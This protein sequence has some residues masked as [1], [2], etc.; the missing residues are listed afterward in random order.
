MNRL[1]LAS[2]FA[3]SVAAVSQQTASAQ[4]ANNYGYL[5]FGFYQPYGATYGT[6]LRTPP[7][8]AMNPPVYYGA[9]HSRPYGISPFA[10]PPVVSAGANYHSRLRTQFEQ[11]RIPSPGPMMMEP[12]PTSNPLCNPCLSQSKAFGKE[13]KIVATEMGATKMGAVQLN[14]FVAQADLI[15]KQ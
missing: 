10:S 14:R 12:R 9:R 4:Q 1:L 13:T 2:L 3:L 15:A 6:S 11:P 8:F 5:P 7:Y